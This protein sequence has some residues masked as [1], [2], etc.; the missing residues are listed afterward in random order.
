M[1]GVEVFSRINLGKETTKGTAV[2]RTRR[3]Y[4]VAA[5]NLDIGDQFAFH[6]E[7]NRGARVRVSA[8]TP[9]LTREMPTFKLQDS[10]PVSAMTT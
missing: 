6:T 7:E 2:A 4:G 5:G 8:H 1:A 9:T 10:A 3:F